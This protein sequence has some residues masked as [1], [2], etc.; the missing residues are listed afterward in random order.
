MSARRS[1]SFARTLWMSV[2]ASKPPQ[3]RRI[4]IS[5][6][7]SST[8]PRTLFP[9][10][11]ATASWTIPDLVTLMIR[12]GIEPKFVGSS[13]VRTAYF[14]NIASF[15]S[16]S[17]VLSATQLVE[18]L[19]EYLST[20][21]H[22]FIAEGG[23]LDKYEGDAI[24]AFFGTPIEQP[25]HAARAVRV[26]LGMQQALA[27]LR[28]K[29]RAEGDKWPDLV[30]N[31]RMRIGISSGDIVVGNMGST[32]RMDYTMM[33]DVVNTAARLEAAA[34]QYGVY[35]LCTTETL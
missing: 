32:M 13:G 35:I 29:W 26:A 34:K 15:S 10:K 20:M 11:V 27:Q 16:F 28:D 18:L 25:D 23:T 5:S 14:T 1:V 9:T 21:T 31:M 30:H 24:L 7:P 8:T 33:G 4:G 17:E 12:D 2:V 22:I 3:A 19:N 6:T